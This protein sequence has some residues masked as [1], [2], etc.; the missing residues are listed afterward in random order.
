MAKTTTE[1]ARKTLRPPPLANQNPPRRVTEFTGVVAAKVGLP[2][3]PA[4]S[5]PPPP[6]VSKPE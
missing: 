5:P 1:Q 4:K 6:P 3:H 2:G